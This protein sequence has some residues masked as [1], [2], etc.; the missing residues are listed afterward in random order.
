MDIARV[1][2]ATLPVGHGTTLAPLPGQAD[3]A[4]TLQDA[5]A[6]VNDLQTQAATATR[7]LVLGRAQSLHDTMIAMEKADISVRLVTQ[8]R[9]KLVEAYQEIMRMQI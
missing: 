4:T 6:A 8:V 2:G 7:D 5:L 1:Q 9:N 3:F